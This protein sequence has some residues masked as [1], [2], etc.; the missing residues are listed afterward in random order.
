MLT[1]SQRC[2]ALKLEDRKLK[3]LQPLH[4]DNSVVVRKSGIIFTQEWNNNTHVSLMS[5]LHVQ[6]ATGDLYS[7]KQ[8]DQ[9]YTLFSELR[10]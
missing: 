8:N 6:L 2:L 9:G 1:P 10:D 7:V 3:S 4:Y 5:L